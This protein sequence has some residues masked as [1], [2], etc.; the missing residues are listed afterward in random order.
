MFHHFGRWI[1]LGMHG[2]KGSEWISWWLLAV[3]DLDESLGISVLFRL[4]FC[5]IWK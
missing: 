2:H 4:L 5:Y 3:F 1:V